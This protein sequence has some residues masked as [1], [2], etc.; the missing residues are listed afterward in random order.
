MPLTPWMVWVRRRDPMAGADPMAVF[1][2]TDKLPVKIRLAPARTRVRL[3]RC[4]RSG[5]RRSGDA[6]R[7]GAARGRRTA[8]SP[9]EETL[10]QER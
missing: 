6:G 10:Q 9:E 4:E 8:S 2:A 3:P 7:E 5:R 1:V